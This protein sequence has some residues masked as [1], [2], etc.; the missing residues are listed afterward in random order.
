MVNKKKIDDFLKFTF[1]NCKYV[2]CEKF[3]KQPFQISLF[4]GK[5]TFYFVIQACFKFH[6]RYQNGMA[7]GRNE[8]EV[9]M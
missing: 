1:R 5:P 7:S 4:W 2:F 3:I 6:L 8:S 9:I